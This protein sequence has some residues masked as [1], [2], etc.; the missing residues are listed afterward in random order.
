MIHM[1][2]LKSPDQ[3]WTKK[4]YKQFLY[5]ITLTLNS[6][7]GPFRPESNFAYI[8][9]WYLADVTLKTIRIL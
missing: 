9:H 5:K 2:K 1:Q 7:G 6:I 8:Q 3:R 4:Y